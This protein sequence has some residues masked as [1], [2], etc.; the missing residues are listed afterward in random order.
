MGR[1]RQ[2]FTFDGTDRRSAPSNQSGENRFDIRGERLSEMRF[3][4]VCPADD[5]YDPVEV[6]EHVPT[7]AGV[8]T[9]RLDDGRLPIEVRIDPRIHDVLQPSEL[10]VAI[11]TGYRE[12]L[13]RHDRPA[14]EAAD[15]E[16]LRS[17]PS[18][19]EIAVRLL[20]TLTLDE[21]REVRRSLIGAVE[22]R[23]FGRGL[24]RDDEPAM[25]L[26]ADR[27]LIRAITIDA[28]WGATAN[29]FTLEY[30]ILDCADQIRAQRPQR[31]THDPYPGMTAAEIQQ[32]SVEHFAT[33]LSR[34][35]IQ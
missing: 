25:T 9:M 12:A 4:P 18:H 26:T 34:S 13:W 35:R 31:A 20:T 21:Y 1:V 14:I 5:F 3:G 15:F 30:D 24:D 8:V 11:M 28:D 27:S 32:L 17:G 23:A 33:L 22:Y 10:A 19:R 29:P 16:A 7:A 2:Q 6:V